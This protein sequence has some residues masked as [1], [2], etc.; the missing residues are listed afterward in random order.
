MYLYLEG[1]KRF[2]HVS[3]DEPLSYYQIAGK[4]L[5]Y[6][7]FQ[8]DFKGIHG[9]PYVNW[10]DPKNHEDIPRVGNDFEGFCT[11]SSIL[12][13]TWHRPYLSLFEV[14]ESPKFNMV[15][16]WFQSALHG[17]VNA[18]ARGI[19]PNHAEKQKYMDLAE[20]FRIP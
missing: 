5:C 12:F 6:L 18:V 7:I 10:P 1:L 3:K 11:H 2:Q 16:N 8:T 15:S 4:L 13:L 19:D 9:L 20:R 17:H 14:C